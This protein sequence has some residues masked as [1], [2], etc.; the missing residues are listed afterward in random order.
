MKIN[1]NIAAAQLIEYNANNAGAN[2]GDCVCRALS[3]AFDVGYV[4]MHKELNEAKKQAR[5]ET[6]KI[7]SVYSRVIRAHGGSGRIPVEVKLNLNDYVDQYMQEGTYIIE[8]APK[9][10]RNSNHIVCVVDGTVYDSWD[11]R[12]QYP[13][14]YYEVTGVERKPF[15]D[16]DLDTLRDEIREAAVVAQN[17]L[18]DKYNWNDVDC[19]VP[20]LFGNKY[21]MEVCLSITFPPCEY[22]SNERTYSFD[23]SIVITPSTTQEEALDIIQKT[24]KVRMY[25][26]FY[27]INKEES[28]RKEEYEVQKAAGDE[29]ESQRWKLFMTSQ[30]SRF[31]NS[32]PGYA[33]GMI[34]YLDIQNPG[35]Y[36][37]SY[38]VKVR[39]LAND[40]IHT[41][42]RFP[43][44]FQ[45]FD[46][47]AMK[48]ML[49]RYY[50]KLELPGE[51]Y[52]E[53]EEY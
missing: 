19:E 17:N 26:R 40:D 38:T 13:K 45:S 53:Y 25:D 50:E 6:W 10:E 3:L 39:K 31:Y 15:T 42:V 47:Y 16:I 43:Y 22:S 29:Q 36:S 34:T 1:H 33:R 8:T 12:N 4:Q 7:T 44:L 30:E 37:D 41:D 5:S 49:K 48:D 20:T 2:T 11:S 28:A 35:Q 21:K 46:A 18:I 51:D 23:Y 24:T 9:P 27:A 32:L 14:N 52:D